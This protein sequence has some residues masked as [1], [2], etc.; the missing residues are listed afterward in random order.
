MNPNRQM[1]QLPLEVL[2]KIL[3]FCSV[4]DRAKCRLVSKVFKKAAE[5]SLRSVTRLNI[6]R[7]RDSHSRWPDRDELPKS[8]CDEIFLV[9]PLVD[10]CVEYRDWELFFFLGQYCPNLQVVSATSFSLE[11][12]QLVQIAS[13]LQFFHCIDLR[14]PSELESDLESLF[15]PFEQLKGFQVSNFSHEL[16]VLFA[17]YLRMR[18]RRMF[19]L[20]TPDGRIVLKMPL[21]FMDQAGISCL[22]IDLTHNALVQQI[23]EALAECLVDLTVESNPR[24]QFCRCPLPKLR[25]LRLRKQR[26]V[27]EPNPLFCQQLTPNLKSFEFD[28][29]VNMSMLRQL[30]SYIHSLDK[31]QYASLSPLASRDDVNDE[32]AVSFPLP[33]KLTELRVEDSLLFHNFSTS[34]RCLSVSE[35]QSCPNNPIS[36][37]AIFDFPN[38]ELFN[39]VSRRRPSQ[40]SQQLLQALSG[41]SKLVTFYLVMFFF[42]L[43]DDHRVQ[44]LIDILQQNPRLT[45]LQLDLDTTKNT[46]KT[47][48]LRQE[49]FPSLKRV[50]LKLP[51]RIVYYPTD[52]FDRL[53]M[54]SSIYDLQQMKLTSESRPM[55]FSLTGTSVIPLFSSQMDK[56]VQLELDLTPEPPHALAFHSIASQLHKINNLQILRFFYSGSRTSSYYL[57][58]YKSHLLELQKVEPFFSAQ[59][60][61]CFFAQTAPND[62]TCRQLSEHQTDAFSDFILALVFGP[63]N[64]KVGLQFPSPGNLD[65]LILTTAMSLDFS[66]LT[67][68]S[69]SS[70]EIAGDVSVPFDLP[71]LRHFCLHPRFKAPDNW[72][73]LGSLGKSPQ[74]RTFKLSIDIECA[75]LPDSSFF[76][77]LLKVASQLKHLET[78]VSEVDLSRQQVTKRNGQVSLHQKNFP[79]LTK[80]VWRAPF[81]FVFHPLDVF[82]CIKVSSGEYSLRGEMP[83]LVY[84]ILEGP[85]TVD[86]KFE[87]MSKLAKLQMDDFCSLPRLSPLNQSQIT[88]VHLSHRWM[89]FKREL[90]ADVMDWVASLLHLRSLVTV[91]SSQAAFERFLR[92]LRSTGPLTIKIGRGSQKVSP[93]DDQLHQL[94]SSLMA[95]GVISSFESTWTCKAEQLGRRANGLASPFCCPP[96]QH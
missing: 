22:S 11:Y 95:R 70:L 84:K 20:K 4:N 73:L 50:E 94:V 13:R 10:V 77:S 78:L 52:S 14:I 27:A 48:F 42:E 89:D 96:L 58:Q 5:I 21:Q 16:D 38:L 74:L 93:M 7:R 45:H 61:K 35:G 90:D 8:Y 19:T 12:E 85:G 36:K 57:P 71:N 41:C 79:S 40:L 92:N 68:Q 6:L 64:S 18:E 69:L 87:N 62:A 31:L 66:A 76:T 30:M 59:N 60:F 28:G 46:G 24:A 33:P 29:E 51:Y 82:D 83:S 32:Q 47:V 43:P 1:D 9:K 23:P 91:P 75:A 80:L 67:S 15:A 44:S 65:K 53:G 25:Y 39:C 54:A 55:D 3:S 81:H 72:A 2:E 26:V 88:E 56:L 49:H 17:K 86:I 34:L 63:H 37:E